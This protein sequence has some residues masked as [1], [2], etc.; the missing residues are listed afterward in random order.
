M[1]MH[2]HTPNTDRSSINQCPTRIILRLCVPHVI[3]P[4]QDD[5][6]IAFIEA[7]ACNPATSRP[8]MVRN[9]VIEPA[10]TAPKKV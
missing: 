4:G 6:C 10:I 2:M 9:M 5:V 3:S 7:Q 8:K 1:H